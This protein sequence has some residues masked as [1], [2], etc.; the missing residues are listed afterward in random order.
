MTN[1]QHIRVGY[2]EGYHNKAKGSFV[3]TDTELQRGYR[4][5]A[6]RE[7]LEGKEPMSYER[8]KQ[9]YSWASQEDVRTSGTTTGK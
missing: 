7:R 5:Y 3:V 1:I 6:N 4:K 8:W 2:A 9:D